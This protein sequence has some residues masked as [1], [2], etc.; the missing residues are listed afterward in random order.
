MDLF[1]NREK[2]PNIICY[3]YGLEN[4]I[5][6]VEK[7]IEIAICPRSTKLLEKGR[8]FVVKDIESTKITTSLA[9]IRKKNCSTSERMD[10]F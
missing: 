10:R 7:G 9:A 8:N 6:L 1:L 4:A 2:H 3:Y 5:A